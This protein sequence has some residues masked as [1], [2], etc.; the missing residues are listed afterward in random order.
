MIANKRLLFLLTDENGQIYY[1]ENGAIKKSA[2]KK[3][4]KRNPNGWKDITLQW[5]TNEKYFSTIRAFSTALKF[6]E[7]GKDIILERL[8]KGKG[9]EEVMYLIILRQ[10]PS[11]G[12]NYYKFEY[13]SRLDFSK[14]T[15]NVR[16]GLSVNLLQDDVFSLVQADEN[17]KY[18]I[19]CNSSNP[20][21]IK[22]LFDGVLMQDKL[23][24]ETINSPLTLT[25][26]PNFWFA[27]PLVFI[28]NEGDSVGTVFNSQNYDNFSDP[29]GYVA[30]STNTN[31]LVYYSAKTKVTLKGTFVFTWSTNTQPSGD[32]TLM[33]MTSRQTL[34]VP[35]G[36]VVFTNTTLTG[37]PH[38]SLEPGKTYS[39]DINLTINLDAGEK[40]F[41]LANLSDNVARHFTITPQPTQIGVIFSTKQSPSIAYALRPLDLLKQLVSK[42]TNGKYTA[43]SKFF[44][45]NNRKVAL[46]G[47]SLRQ[48]ADAQIQTS[49]ADWFQS[50]TSAYNLG[51]TVRNGVL[52]VEPIE[53]IYNSNRQLLNLG[54][55]SEWELQV[56]EQ[57]IYT[58]AKFGY[59]KQNYNKRNG[60]YEF[61]C[62]HNYKF[63]VYTVL[64]QLNRVSV[65]H[66]APFIMEFIRM[67]LQNLSS[68]DDKG[69][70]EVFT[71]MIS[72]SVG[73]T[74]GDV[75]TAV[76]FTVQTLTIA[77]PVIKSPNSNTTVYNSQPTI[78]GISQANMTITVFVDGTIDGIT[79]SDLNGNWTYQVQRVLQSLSINYNGIHRIEAMASASGG[80]DS[81]F[82]KEL[83]ITVD[84]QSTSAFIITG[85]TNND[86]LYNNLPLITGTAPAGQAITISIDG[87]G[88]A[89]VT[90]NTSS[91]WAHQLT[92]PM[93]DGTHTISAMSPGLAN[94]PDVTIIVN[95]NVSSPLITSISYGD[96]IY[97]NLP[98]IHGVAQAGATVSVYLDGG[99]GAIV[100][101]VAGPLGTTVADGAGDWSFTVTTVTDSSGTV[102][103][104]MPDGLHIL[105]TTPTPVNVQ[106]AISGYKLMRGSNKG[107]VMDYD[108]IKLDDEYIPPGI[109]PSSLP[110]TLGQ[111]LHPETL[112]NIEETTPLRMLRAHDNI[113]KSFLI[114]QPAEKVAFNGAELNANLVTKKNGVVFNEGAD[115]PN[116]DL[117]N[118][119]FLPWYLN[120]KAKVPFT[121]NQIM[122][123]VNNDGY[124]T[125]M[126]KGIP[127]D[128][129]PV[130]SMSM[131]LATNE[132]QSWKLLISGRTPFDY[133][134]KIFSDVVTINIGKNMIYISDKNPLHFVK[135][136]YTPPAG[137]HFADIY[138]DWQKNRF[139]KWAV[140]PD[141]AQP[142]MKGDALPIQFPTNGVTG[143]QLLMVSCTTGNVIDT[144]PFNVVPSIVVPLPMTLQE[145]AV[146]TNI[147]PEGQYWFAVS[148]TGT[149]VAISEKI[150]LRT[151]WPDTLKIEY[152]GSKD[153]IDYYF[154]SGIQPMIRVQGQLL[155][156]QQNAEVDVY[157][158][159]EGDY[160]TTRAIPTDIRDIQFGDEFSLISDWMAR[161]LN[162][163]TCLSNW[164]VEETKY[165]RY[166]DSKWDKQDFGVGV[167]EV[168]VKMSI[169][170]GTHQLGVEI[171]TPD[172]T[173]VHT[174]SFVLDATAFG[175][176]AG[177]INV[178]AEP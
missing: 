78:A 16:T 167:P 129:L 7:D 93:S 165:T 81:G 14:A 6:V 143:L 101:G 59:Q 69:D 90:T 40:L 27:V 74:D 178:T 147:Y 113:L 83:S 134:I 2:L 105:S 76:S 150:D 137:C 17:T 23:N 112:F 85:P 45:N 127:I 128:C 20:A 171:S 133:L 116:A 136:N 67:D 152:G 10:D 29:N 156:W 89:T 142:L 84:T 163:I 166:S 161:K 86:T 37:H 79:T 162:A 106:A 88:V 9:T 28:N 157:E 75:S 36:Q 52:W 153:T 91:L 12:I 73:Q 34:P 126:C 132:A 68:T 31:C 159:E 131:K 58:S 164:R 155:P 130:G 15:P 47:S 168:M 25:T 56:A 49:F 48:F 46:S 125:V 119:L 97:N 111:F 72:D 19:P 144:I 66:A 54:E 107:P 160:E 169:T 82:S 170:R 77:T 50:Y 4:L 1:K 123:G 80:A 154:S 135:Y 42:I 24:Y 60:R 13:K 138:D 117:K 18:S 99:G 124:I 98:T 8:I 151:D 103:N 108:V 102:T 51:V 21:A 121:F 32:V 176:N 35:T 177:V 148:A 41:F 114:Q 173:G 64:N 100:G 92:A 11:G 104:Y 96:V 43:N 158:D 87:V 33:F 118:N 70:N 22:V 110:P 30:S 63:P 3:W 62:T 149:I 61:N 109:D 38:F 65:Y 115:V 95:K 57:F 174:T 141:Y 120:F 94:A 140:Q 71:A 146:D 39:A 145:C 55:A 139:A 53:D 44:T 172:D 5:A 26:S 122:T 175:Q